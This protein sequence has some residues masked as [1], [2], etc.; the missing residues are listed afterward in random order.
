MDLRQA[1]RGGATVRVVGIGASAGGVDAL[2]QVV[3][4]LPASLPVALC[5]VLH[6]P[7][8]G[9]SLLAPILARETRLAVGVA[10][11]GERLRAGRVY[12]APN[13]RHLVVAD[14]AVVLDDGPKENGVRPA[15]DPLLRSLAASYG[16]EAVAVI[17]SGALADG[18]A[19]ALA[20]CSAGGHVIVQ[21]PAEATV[22]SMPES[23]L[24]AV[25][26]AGDVLRAAAIG[27]ALVAL[28]GSGRVAEVAE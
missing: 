19:G 27:P 21:D 5:V 4:E 24:S 9:T 6:V 13:D 28:L 2:V 14:G 17:L 16:A 25:G 11:D 22:R 26:R 3:R 7:S 10:Q 15:V 20:V 8:A 23:A 1:E 12:V 18:S